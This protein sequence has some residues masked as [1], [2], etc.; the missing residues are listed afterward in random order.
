MSGRPP[1]SVLARSPE[2]FDPAAVSAV[3]ARRRGV[4]AAALLPA[5]RA[6]WGLCAEA[7]PAEEAE[8]LAAELTAA[9]QDA[10]AVPSSLVEPLPDAVPATK[11]DLVGDGFDLNAGKAGAA[12]ERLSWGSLRALS[13]GGVG[14]R[15]IIELSFSEPVRRVRVFA[16]DFDYSLLGPEMAYSADLNF[17]LL[18]ARLRDAAPRALRGRGARAILDKRP[19][20]ESAYSSFEDFARELRWLTA[21]AVLGARR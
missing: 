7:L 16:D 13:A 3:L 19:S 1:H 20:G 10:L 8:S 9:G 6:A 18:V 5:A 14:G 12:R 4:E 17:R 2:R 11:A 21:L 15:S